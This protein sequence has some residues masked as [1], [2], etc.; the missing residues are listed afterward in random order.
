LLAYDVVALVGGFLGC[1]GGGYEGDVY[2]DGSVSLLD[3][4]AEAVVVVCCVGEAVGEMLV[5][6]GVECASLRSPW[7][8]AYAFGTDTGAGDT[9][10]N[11]FVVS[12]S[13]VGKAGM[14][15]RF[16]RVDL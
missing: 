14:S 3:G 13:E 12:G 11:T 2:A 6:G 5:A 16:L 10:G 9:R 7:C 4:F 15:Y 8:C 1:G